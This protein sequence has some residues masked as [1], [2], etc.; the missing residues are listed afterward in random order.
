MRRTGGG[1]TVRLPTLLVGGMLALVLVGFLAIGLAGV[2][3]AEEDP[4]PA[5]EVNV[6][7]ESSDDP[8]ELEVSF[9]DSVDD[10]DAVADVEF[11]EAGDDGNESEAVV[12][13]TIDGQAGQTIAQTFD[14][15]DYDG[16]EY[17][18]E[19]TVVVEDGEQIEYAERLDG[20][21]I[22]GGGGGADSVPGFGA[23]VAIVALATAGVLAVRRE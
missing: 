6:S 9:N 18:E 22:G 19:Y 23:V 5:L 13:E 12:T 17:S 1:S 2:A 11:Y 16:L 7:Y 4:E 20:G 15:A 14:W 3:A 21:L 8:L 10:E